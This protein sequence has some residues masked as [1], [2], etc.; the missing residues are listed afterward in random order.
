MRDR[1]ETWVQSLGPEDPL[2]LKMATHSRI[3]AWEDSLE[4]EM[5]TTAMFLPRKSQGQ[6]ILAGNSYGT[7]KSQIRLSMSKHIST[8]EVK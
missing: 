8:F 2:E 6:S 3:L 4:E 1:Q 5:A 7:T